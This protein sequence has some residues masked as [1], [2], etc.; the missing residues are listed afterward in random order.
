MLDDC[1]VD[2]LKLSAKF[3]ADASHREVSGTESGS[4]SVGAVEDVGAM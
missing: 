2:N 4:N 3:K 1:T